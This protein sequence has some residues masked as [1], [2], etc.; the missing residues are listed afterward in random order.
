MKWRS[1][2]SSVVGSS[3]PG[4]QR[5]QLAHQV[6]GLHL[7]IGGL[8]AHEAAQPSELTVPARASRPS[9]ITTNAL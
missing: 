1:R 9:L 5:F 2:S 6:R 8:P 4:D 3:M 7:A